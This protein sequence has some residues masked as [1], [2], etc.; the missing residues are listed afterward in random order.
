MRTAFTLGLVFVAFPFAVASADEALDPGRLDPSMKGLTFGATRDQVVE[1][2]KRRAAAALNERIDTTMDT[3]D[4]DR[5][6]REKEERVAA[7]GTEMATFDSRRSGWDVS[8]VRGEF[9]Y[10]TGESMLVVREGKDQWYFFFTNGNFYKLIRTGTGRPMADWLADAER[11][12]GPPQSVKPADPK[13][14]M[15]G[16]VSATWAS[17]LLAFDVQDQSE[18]FACVTYRWA[19]KTADDQVKA[20]WE[21]TR[22]ADP[23]LNPLVKEAITPPGGEGIDPVDEMIGKKPEPLPQPRKATPKTKPKKP[24]TP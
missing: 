21:R 5:L 20:E 7:I 2:L 9:A 18:K 15:A 3:R 14:P 17:G 10:G 11:R 12:Y 23:G 8:V 4:R 19:L 13:S 6:Q 22:K 16:L 1:F 24:V